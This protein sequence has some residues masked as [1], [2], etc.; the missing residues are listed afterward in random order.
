[1]KLFTIGPVQMHPETLQARSRPIPYFRTA[2][3]SRF[4]L[5]MDRKFKTVLGTAQDN[6][7]VYLTASGSAAMEATVMN[8]FTWEDKLLIIDGG[9]FGSRFVKICQIHHI[10][11]TPLH[12]DFGE[13]L[14]AAHLAPYEGQG[15]TGLL[16][17]LD[18]SSTGQLYDIRMLHGFC[19]RN[20]SL[21]VVDTITSFL[22]DEYRMDEFGADVSIVSSQKGLALSP[23]LSL[24]A[25]NRRAKARSLEVGYESLYFSFRDYY[26][27]M[28]RGQMP[29]TP[30]IGIF[31]ELDQ[32]LDMLLAEGLDRHLAQVADNAAYFRSRLAEIGGR[33]PDYPVSNAITPVILDKPIAKPLFE[34][35]MERGYTV[36]P[37]GGA[38]ADS[39]IR[40]AHVGDLH[41]EDYDELIDAIKAVRAEIG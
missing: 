18:E 30:A 19:E 7:V 41:R 15:Y 34:K 29:Y 26:S 39:M 38:R 11:H 37:V 21:L 25:L 33:L 16:V 1:M 2:E 24:I 17:N 12:L 20:G 40:V 9:T 35:L 6:E 36:N 22:C 8:L 13:T 14:T 4:T 10:P 31:M 5:E 32:M 27:N 23:G 28:E 3:F